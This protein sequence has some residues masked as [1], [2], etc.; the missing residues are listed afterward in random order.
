[1]SSSATPAAA[2]AAAAAPAAVEDTVEERPKN[3]SDLCMRNTP[4]N[5]SVELMFKIAKLVQQLRMNNIW[6]GL[7]YTL[8]CSGWAFF[9]DL[10]S[11]NEVV[12]VEDA[13]S[14]LLFQLT[15]R[16]EKKKDGDLVFAKTIS[17][18]IVRFFLK[19][20]TNCR[21][22]YDAIMKRFDEMVKVPLRFCYA[23]NDSAM[24]CDTVNRGKGVFSRKVITS[25]TPIARYVDEIKKYAM[26]TQKGTI[27]IIGD[28]ML[29]IFELIV[30]KFE[31]YAMEVTPRNEKHFEILWKKFQCDRDFKAVNRGAEQKKKHF[32]MFFSKAFELFLNQFLLSRIFSSRFEEPENPFDTPFF[33]VFVISES[34]FEDVIKCLGAV[35]IPCH[36]PDNQLVVP[37][38]RIANYFNRPNS[39]EQANARFERQSNGA[40]D[41]V[42]TKQIKLD[43]EILVKYGK[44]FGGQRSLEEVEASFKK[45]PGDSS[46]ILSMITML[47][48]SKLFDASAV[49]EALKDAAKPITIT[50]K[51]KRRPKKAQKRPVNEMVGKLLLVYHRTEW[52][53]CLVTKAHKTSSEFDLL[54]LR[55]DLSISQHIFFGKTWKRF[56]LGSDI[57]KYMEDPLNSPL[58]AKKYLEEKGM[59]GMNPYSTLK[60]AIWD[61]QNVFP[62][63]FDVK[64]IMETLRKVKS[65]IQLSLMSAKE[66]CENLNGVMLNEEMRYSF[67]EMYA[68]QKANLN[69]ILGLPA[70][71]LE[72]SFNL[73]FFTK[74]CVKKEFPYYYLH[75]SNDPTGWSTVDQVEFIDGVVRVESVSSGN[76]SVFVY[77]SYA[78]FF[79]DFHRLVDRDEIIF[80][81]EEQPAGLFRL[82]NP[83]AAAETSAPAETTVPAAAETS[84]VPASPSGSAATSS[85][86]STEL[87]PYVPVET[88]APA[89]IKFC[90]GCKNNKSVTEFGKN[91]RHD[92]PRS[93][94]RVCHKEYNKNWYHNNLDKARANHRRWKAKSKRGKAKSKRGAAETS[95]PAPETPAPAA[96]APRWQTKK[97]YVNSRHLCHVE[98]CHHDFSQVHS[99]KQHILEKHRL[100]ELL[101]KQK[102]GT[103]SA[104]ERKR[105][106][107]L[108]CRDSNRKARDKLFTKNF[109][110]YSFKCHLCRHDYMDGYTT[111]REMERHFRHEHGREATEDDW[112]LMKKPRAS[113]ASS[114]E[115]ALTPPLTPPSTPL[116][117]RE[118]NVAEILS[119]SFSRKRKRNDENVVCTCQR[120]GT[121][122]CRQCGRSRL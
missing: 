19:F 40:V 89:L 105:F 113:L 47:E 64:S 66:K 21:D 31:Q 30:A 68:N 18:Q 37:S 87:E 12:F 101:K 122:H 77:D 120:T 24:V 61:E 42:S 112:L 32:E 78:D 27:L 16:K 55:T 62:E 104:E 35:V 83:P 22:D 91:R 110:P 109:D 38:K 4:L 60:A 63:R 33:E 41:V 58:T 71:L 119:S 50:F 69:A 103:L 99:L 46:V 43:K 51:A 96:E 1:M 70:T 26:G 79:R 7:L 23:M 75:D 11:T 44:E 17:G 73:R 65:E 86:S 29:P 15:K 111:K 57:T 72:T 106:E 102:E 116:S 82:L 52:W 76:R 81:G 39:D 114:S 10:Y 54:C 108:F 84:S 85:A 95:T 121:F 28:T 3:F 14:S 49:F 100:R 115:P 97:G 93:R 107:E 90:N 34:V 80:Q 9:V 88:S 2:A 98:G 56:K 36:V 6:R 117:S 53:P 74:D 94:C 67:N 20:S 92:G 13:S 45:C 48:R 8:L 25:N 5:R 118:A 59:D